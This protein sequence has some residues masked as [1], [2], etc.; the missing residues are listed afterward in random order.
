MSCTMNIKFL[1]DLQRRTINLAYEAEV[2]IDS[3]L[4]QYNAFLHS[5]CSLPTILKEIMQINAEV[6]EMWSTDIPLNP[7]YVAAPFKHL[8]A[9]H[10]NPVT[11]EEVVGFEN[12]AEELIDYL[13]RG[14]NELDVV[15]IVGM[16]GQGKTTIA[17]KL[18]NNDI[19]VSHFDVR[20]WCIISQTYSRR[21]LLQEI[22]SQVMGSKDKE[23]AVGE[24]AD[25]LRKSLMGKRYLIVLD[26][27]WDCMAW[28][29]LRLSFPDVGMRSRIV[30]TTRQWV[31]KSSTILI[32]ILFHSSQQKRVA[33]CCRKKC[34]K[35][36]IARLN[37][38]M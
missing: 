33:N 28:D 29:D 21:E 38:N 27:M 36:K 11:D 18:Y 14:T 30:V 9:Q 32:L 7:H 34:F 24:L 17:R 10:S 3:I 8:P 26:D 1:K 20:A 25:R 6:T 2:A 13:I 15:P 5:F 19:I 37:Y 23:D 35:R 16:G 4:A 22:F 31:S 12:K